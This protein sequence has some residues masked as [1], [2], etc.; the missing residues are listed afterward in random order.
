MRVARLLLL[1][2]LPVPALAQELPEDPEKAIR[3]VIAQWYDELG[4][5]PGGHAYAV[6][7]SPFIEATP[8]YRY[9][10]TG[11]AVLGPPVYDSLAATA[12]E[13][14]YDVEFMRVD[15]SFA[16]VGVWERGYFYAFAAGRTYERAAA[17]DFILERREKDGRW[18]VVAHRT[19]SI[20]IPP[21]RKTDPMPDLRDVFYATVGKDRDPEADAREA[22]KF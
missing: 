6:V 15:A 18:L 17:T 5:G 19:R 4:K 21:N 1:L 22:D 13:F 3:A 7:G 20:G 10:D 16:R 11:A 9:I 2:L 12:L 14:A 8:H